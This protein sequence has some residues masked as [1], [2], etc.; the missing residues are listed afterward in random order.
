M[1]QVVA[2][3]AADVLARQRAPATHPPRG[4]PGAHL[5]SFTTRSS[6]RRLHQAEQLPHRYRLCFDIVLRDAAVMNR[7]REGRVE[8]GAGVVEWTQ[9]I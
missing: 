2:G 7:E 5:Y 9:R 1:P 3:G 4:I 8:S 6:K